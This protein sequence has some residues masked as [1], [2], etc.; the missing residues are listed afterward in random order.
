LAGENNGSDQRVDVLGVKISATNMVEA[1]AIIKRWIEQDEKHYVC[2]TGVHGV[3]ECQRDE[4]LRQIHNGSGL[5][6][7]DGMPMVWAGKSFGVRHM[8]RVYGPDL[9]LAVC[10]MSAGQGF[11]NFLYGGGEGVAEELRQSL[12][13]KCPGVNIVG[14]YTPPFRPLNGAE[15]RQLI[16]Q[17]AGL[18][19]DIFWVGLSTP[20][21]ERFMAEYLPKLETKVMLGVGAAFDIH[22]GRV[23]DAPGWV[24]KTGLQWFHRLVQEPKRLWKRYLINNPI[25][26]VK[27]IR[28]LII[29]KRN[30]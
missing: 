4:E 23:K 25:F 20:K 15:E 22:T 27:F 11:T 3:M 30:D 7:P 10:T 16:E 5:T 13:S 28:Q 6:V 9:M 17:V 24:K 18:K 26:I 21:Q 29:Q 14:T 1:T 2:V 12:A 19:P 8:G